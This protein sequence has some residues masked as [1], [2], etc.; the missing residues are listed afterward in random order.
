MAAAKNALRT[1]M[2]KILSSAANEK[3]QISGYGFLENRGVALKKG[4]KYEFN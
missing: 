3:K 1:I 4:L 2:G